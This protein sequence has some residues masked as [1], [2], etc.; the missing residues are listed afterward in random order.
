MCTKPLSNLCWLP[1]SLLMLRMIELQ[2]LKNSW[3]PSEQGAQC[4]KGSLYF[5]KPVFTEYSRCFAKNIA[6][7]SRCAASYKSEMVFCN[8]SW[9]SWVVSWRLMRPQ[10]NEIAHHKTAESKALCQMYGVTHL[11]TIVPYTNHQTISLPKLYV[12]TCF[13]FKIL[14]SMICH[15]WYV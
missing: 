7:L 10:R 4:S 15:A 11:C 14:L 5:E 8:R 13:H 12:F 9:F 1:P 6:A 3:C 2:L